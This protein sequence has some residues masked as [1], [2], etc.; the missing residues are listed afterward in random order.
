[1]CTYNDSLILAT[2]IFLFTKQIMGAEK[3]V[4]KTAVK[5]VYKQEM[6]VEVLSQ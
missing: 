6:G 3:T 4:H 1:M 2:P 5:I